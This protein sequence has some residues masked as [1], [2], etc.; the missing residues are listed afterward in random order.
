MIAIPNMFQQSGWLIPTIVMLVTMLV[1]SFA[2]TFM[3]D[4]MSRMPGNAHFTERVELTTLSRRLFPRWAHTLTVVMF[5]L[6]LQAANI[7]S[8]IVSAQTMDLTLV[9]IRDTCGLE[10]YP[11]FRWVCHSAD[12]TD[13]TPFG[14]IYVISLG[15]LIVLAIAVPLGFVNLDDN[16]IV[17]NVS[18]VIMFIIIG[19]WIVIFFLAGLRPANLPVITS[20]QAG[21]LGT[22]IFNYAFVVTVPSWVNEKKPNVSPN[23]VL[24]GS[25]I[26]STLLFMIMGVGGAL[27]FSFVGSQDLLNKLNDCPFLPGWLSVIA[28]ISVYLFPA[29][30]LISGIP[31]ASVVVRYN[32]IEDR[33]CSKAWANWW[34]VVFPWLFAVPYVHIAARFAWKVCDE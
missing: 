28:K 23:L 17:Q 27:A 6:A 18:A 26:L 1:S 12:G 10:L 21:V 14:N 7:A 34:A 3:V 24:W 25:S 15:F 9:A 33:I 20:S 4:A 31:I 13:I 2:A 30:T 32:L 11:H 22:V 8:I 29:V 16:I 19:F 5:V